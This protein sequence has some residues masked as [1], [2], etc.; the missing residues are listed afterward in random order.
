MFINI[1]NINVYYEITGKGSPVL[2]LHGWGGSISSFKPLTDILQQNYNV[3]VLDFPGFGKSDVPE[4]PWGTSSYTVFLAKFMEQIGLKQTDIIAHSFGGRVAI[5]LAAEHPEMVNKLVLVNSAGIKPHRTYKY[6]LKTFIAKTGKIAA[7]I[8][9]ESGKKIKNRIYRYIG[10]KDFLNAGPMRSILIKIINE[11]L[12]PL[13]KRIMSPTLLIW[14]ENDLE[15]PVY[16]GK[17]MEREI[18]NAGLVV[19]KNAGHYSYLDQFQHF[20]AIIANFLKAPARENNGN[21]NT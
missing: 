2:L 7:K 21:L 6:Y 3:T 15:T 14:G 17:I 16:M 5:R 13:L 20:C 11:D 19:L 10:S 1:N 9:G 8:P 12:Q 4:S 18:K